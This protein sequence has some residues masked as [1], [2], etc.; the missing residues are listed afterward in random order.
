MCSVLCALLKRD[1]CR[2]QLSNC[3]DIVDFDDGFLGLKI[4]KMH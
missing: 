1:E 2:Q 4:W 3:A